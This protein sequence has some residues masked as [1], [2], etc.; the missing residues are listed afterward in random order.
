MFN[1]ISSG[2]R[3]NE[4][5][6]LANARLVSLYAKRF[7]KGQWSFIG[8]GSA[9][10]WSSM[11]EDSL[12]GVWDN[13]AERMLLEFA[14]S[15]CPIFR[16]S[17]PLSRGRLQSRGHGQLSIHFAADEETIETFSHN[18]FSSVFTVQSQKCVKNM[19]PFMIERG[20]PLSEGNQ[21]PH[22]CPVWSR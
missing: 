8:L 6:C 2:T 20:N 5:E 4:H 15:T 3:D 17:S 1:N 18:I 21:V 9:K 19:N 16:A 11:K 10:K 13:M 22:S 14:E 7:G 12:Q